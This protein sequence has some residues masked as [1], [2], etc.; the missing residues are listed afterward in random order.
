MAHSFQ[1]R[2]LEDRSLAIAAYPLFRACYHTCFDAANRKYERV[3]HSARRKTSNN[4]LSMLG[5]GPS[6]CIAAHVP[7][8]KRISC[9]V[10]P[11]T[12]ANC[13]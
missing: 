8:G 5:L 4:L 10:S 11:T 6:I 12:G 1:S 3:H 2:R 9:S 7:I 13:L